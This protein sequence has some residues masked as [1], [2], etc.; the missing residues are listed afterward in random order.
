MHFRRRGP[1][2]HDGPPDN[3][4]TDRTAHHTG[5]HNDGTANNSGASGHDT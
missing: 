3:G 5:T 4:G 2:R 1:N